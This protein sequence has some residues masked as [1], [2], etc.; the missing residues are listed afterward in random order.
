MAR[1]LFLFFLLSPAISSENEPAQEVFD[2]ENQ[3]A[4]AEVLR[5][6]VK[7]KWTPLTNKS[8]PFH[9]F[10]QRLGLQYLIYE[11]TPY[12]GWYG[13][14]DSNDTIRNLR[15]FSDGKLEGPVFSWKHNG[16]KNYQG[17]YHKGEKHGTFTYWNGDYRKIREQTYRNG[18]LD[19]ITTSWYGNGQK[20]SVQTFAEGKILS[21]T[22]WKPN[23]ERCPSTRVVNGIGVLLLHDELEIDTVKA[24][25]LAEYTIERYVNGN[26]REEGSYLNGKKEGL[27]IYYRTN[28]AE[29]FRAKYS[30]G[31]KQPSFN[32]S[33]A[34][35]P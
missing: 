10:Q 21:A 7:G 27:W 11:K 14:W 23:G 4:V 25:S 33:E 15:Y 18:K 17:N 6:S 26:K 1:F 32:S 20:S 24:P 19:G 8:L 35:L 12:T 29:F 9:E 16:G 28:G 31:K 2:I 13:Q 5:N 30:Q 22:G 34:I 3:G